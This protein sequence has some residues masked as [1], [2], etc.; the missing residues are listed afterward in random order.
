VDPLNELVIDGPCLNYDDAK[1]L[2]ELFEHDGSTVGPPWYTHHHDDSETTH[3]KIFKMADRRKIDGLCELA[4]TRVFE[5]P[6]VFL[7]CTARR[8]A[9]DIL[10]KDEMPDQKRRYM[11]IA[12]VLYE[13]LNRFGIRSKATEIIRKYPVLRDYLLHGVF[14]DQGGRDFCSAALD[15]LPSPI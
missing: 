12:K 4:F 14:H 10:M 15:E 7:D 2:I 9:I 8:D 6:E 11:Q 5:T 1:Q 13:D 3:A